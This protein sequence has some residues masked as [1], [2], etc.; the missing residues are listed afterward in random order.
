[1]KGRRG[2]GSGP[3]RNYETE[4]RLGGL[5][6]QIKELRATQTEDQQWWL[7]LAE[8]GLNIA[9]ETMTEAIN[10]ERLAMRQVGALEYFY[11]QAVENRVRLQTKEEN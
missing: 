11:R 6:E 7:D 5:A 1:M 3:E 9:T 2:P 10:K 4:R 8:N